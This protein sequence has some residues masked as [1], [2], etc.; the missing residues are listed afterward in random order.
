MQGVHDSLC[1]GQTKAFMGHELRC[2]ALTQAGKKRGKKLICS[3]NTPYTRKGKED[4]KGQDTA[5]PLHLDIGKGPWQLVS[6][7]WTKTQQTATSPL[8]AA[9]CSSP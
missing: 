8:K 1:P 6:V 5:Y 3:R 2:T 9:Q 4:T 7:S